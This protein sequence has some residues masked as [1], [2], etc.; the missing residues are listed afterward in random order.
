MVVA[1]FEVTRRAKLG[2]EPFGG[3]G[4]LMAGAMTA[5]EA[6]RAIYFDFEGCVGEAPSILGWSYLRDDGTEHFRQRVVERALWPASGVTVP[7]TDGRQKLRRR[8]LDDAV[9]RMLEL[10]EEGDRFLVSWATHDRKIVE[11]YV[12]NPELTERLRA[13]YRNA[14]KTARPWLREVHPEI[15]LVKDWGG[16]HKLA[17]YA[18]I[19]KITIPA[20]YGPGIAASGIRTMR[21][22]L[23]R[24]GTYANISPEDRTAWKAL[25]GHNRLDCRVCGKVV[26]TAAADRHP[27]VL[28]QL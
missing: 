10:A 4:D 20:K 28:E 2:G 19:Q 9:R 11:E 12:T 3:E 21:A 16:A 26:R 15:E 17:V 23:A 1:P 24:H 25:L 6:R 13:R 5:D 18:R 8:M 22:A 14:L 27:E 7:H